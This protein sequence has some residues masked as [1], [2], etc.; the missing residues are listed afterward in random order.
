MVLLHLRT[1]RFVSSNI[2]FSRVMGAELMNVVE[3]HC[4]KI[5]NVYKVVAMDGIFFDHLAS[6]NLLR[7]PFASGGEW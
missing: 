6:L 4:G 5:W 2:S 1:A 7:L 3:Y